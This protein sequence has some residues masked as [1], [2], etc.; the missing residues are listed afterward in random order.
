MRTGC[1]FFLLGVLLLCRLRELPPGYLVF[2]LPAVVL[3]GYLFP[4]LRLAAYFGAGLLV[5]LFHATLSLS[6]ELPSILEGRDLIVEGEIASLPASNARSWRFELLADS[7]SGLDGFSHDFR[8]KIRLNWFNRRQALAI[9]E[10]WKLMVRL[11]RPSGFSNPGGFD[12]E[13]WL[14]HRGI[15]AT[16]YV[17]AHAGNELL[18]KE[19]GT[20]LGSLRQYLRDKLLALGKHSELGALL[21]ALVTG[22]RS[23]VPSE[24]WQ[25]LRA[26]GTSHLLAISGLHIGLV[27]GF[28]FFLCRWLWPF[29]RYMP[30]PTA[31]TLASLV[32]AISYAAMAGFAVPTQRALLM[33][34]IYSGAKLLGKQAE[35][36]WII[37]L[38]LLFVLLLDPFSSQSPGFWL[39]FGAV[40]VI[41]F[42]MSSRV[43]TSNPWWRWGRVQLVVA[44][45]LLPLLASLFNQVPLYG[46]LANTLAVPWISFTTVPL[47]L[48]GSLF[49]LVNES[50]AST[51]LG[52][53]LGSLEMLWPFLQGLADLPLG[54]IDV[55]SPGVLALVS[56][57]IGA[58]ILLLPG[59]LASRRI[60][61][62]WLLPLAVPS[63]ARLD[64][65]E[66]RMLVFDVG[67]GTAAM[68]ITRGHNLLFDT[69]PRFSS[70]FDA[71][72]GVIY[73]Y[74]RRRGLDSVDML[75]QSH[76]D[77]DHIGGLDALDRLVD[78]KTIKSGVPIGFTRAPVQPCV[79]GD[80]W[81]WDGVEFRI[82]HPGI[83]T[84][85]QGNNASCVLK[86]SS[87][88]GSVLLSG[89]IE[90]K[91]ERAILEHQQD[92]LRSRVLV[93]PHHGSLTS[94][95]VGFVRAVRPDISIFTTGYRN[96][97]RFPKQD[98]IRRY[99]KA[100]SRVLDTSR[101][102]AIDIALM[103]D[104]IV[105]TTNRQENSRFWSRKAP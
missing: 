74:L 68:V 10:R 15:R 88:F 67:Q 89:D 40:S 31:A 45:G 57:I 27:A 28:G 105:V 12:Y 73:P 63:T 41:L 79:R 94:S 4:R 91:A 34:V 53:A 92:K 25:V 13:G 95:T 2:F 21:P 32:V 24:T 54:R 37:C 90:R 46:F 104:G 60:G 87:K 50:V 69:G 85:F 99:E 61:L 98:I 3:A 14:F 11:K 75:V 29:S 71:G 5:A 96:R 8:G 9:G 49:L 59:G 66:F 16:G 77:I 76:A 102:G 19:S 22:D 38:A 30:A 103:D 82:L 26:T 65:G 43:A 86:I 62:F 33:L 7:V 48:A 52:L 81:H 93:V 17:K 55:P 72:S 84:P 78:I 47:V 64:D 80:Y 42:A 58:A 83:D 36:S 51:L 100:G 39:S 97:F 44:T 56:T 101:H 1:M 20:T 23:E 6:Q 18:R 70:R 35:V